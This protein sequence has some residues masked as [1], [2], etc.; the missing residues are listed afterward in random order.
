MVPHPDIR[1][2]RSPNCNNTDADNRGD[3]RDGDDAVQ[4]SRP[5]RNTG[6]PA[7]PMRALM[8][9]LRSHWAMASRV[10]Y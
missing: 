3:D 1:E 4:D 2:E 10:M 5:E 7:M 6:T 8:M 9:A